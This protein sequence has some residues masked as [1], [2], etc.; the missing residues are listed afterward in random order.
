MRAR[1]GLRAATP[2]CINNCTHPRRK[3]LHNHSGVASS[4]VGSRSDFLSDERI[5]ASPDLNQWVQLI[6]AA[7]SGLGLGAIF[8]VPGVLGP[9]LC[10]TQGVVAQAATDFSM[11]TLVP[12]MS[13][14]PLVASSLAFALASQS[15]AFGT[16]RLALA[17]STIY[18]LGCFVLAAAAVNSNSYGGF[19]ASYV[20]LGGASLF[21]PSA[22]WR[23]N[24]PPA[25]S[26]LPA[27]RFLFLLR[28]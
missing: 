5:V 16:R 22:T 20:L 17:S 26:R 15:D 12:T 3:F 28:I 10:K 9:H 7:L 11:G 27:Y 21:P 1:A 2:R 24:L 8:V 13:L 25:P 18:P 19:M 4:T 23:S 14:M 6:P